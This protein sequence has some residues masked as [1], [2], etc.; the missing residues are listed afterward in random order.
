MKEELEADSKIIPVEG[1][2]LE[3]K[4]ENFERDTRGN[5]EGGRDHH[6]CPHRHGHHGPHNG[7][8]GH[9]GHHGRRHHGHCP[10]PAILVI[11]FAAHVYSLKK[12]RSALHALD[13]AKAAPVVAN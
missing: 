4:W 9:H 12:F 7:G 10:V 8:E 6:R 1:A 3:R 5:H 13:E 11:L 2:D